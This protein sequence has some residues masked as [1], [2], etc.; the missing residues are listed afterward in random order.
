MRAGRPLTTTAEIPAHGAPLIEEW[1]QRHRERR[2][3]A[4]PCLAAGSWP[5]RR[6]AADHAARPV[7]ASRRRR[8]PAPSTPPVVQALECDGRRPHRRPRHAPT[9]DTAKQRQSDPDRRPD[10]VAQ[11][12]RR[13][14]SS[15]GHHTRPASRRTAPT[16]CSARATLSYTELRWYWGKAAQR[17]CKKLGIKAEQ[18]W[19]NEYYFENEGE[20]LEVRLDPD[21]EIMAAERRPQARLGQPRRADRGH[22]GSD[23]AALPVPAEGRRT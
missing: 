7:A 12:R 2:A 5:V 17:R 3:A 20:R 6:R 4:V 10:Q 15:P 9:S 21:V 23:L 19:C 16:W 13:P 1:G 22:R 8:H 11:S 14:V 18:A